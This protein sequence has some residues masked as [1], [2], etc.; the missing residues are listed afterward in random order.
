MHQIATLD[1]HIGRTGKLVLT[2]LLGIL[3]GALSVQYIA[4]AVLAIARSG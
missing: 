2:R 4:D 3:Q 1:R